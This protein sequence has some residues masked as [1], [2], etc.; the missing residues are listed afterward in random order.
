MKTTSSLPL[1]L[2]TFSIGIVLS[3]SSCEKVKDLAKF[4]I[5]YSNPDIRFTLDSMDYL[6]KSEKL[7]LEQTLTVNIDSII[8]KHELDGIE[9]AKFE[10]VSIE[11]E[12]PAQANFNWLTSARAT[13]S[14]Q[15]INE[16]E[17]AATTS[18]AADGRSVDLTLS[19]TEVISQISTG[20]FTLRL[21][22]N[23]TPPLPAG[24]LMMLI[25]SKIKMTVKPL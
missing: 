20:S 14:A 6:P 9:N 24:T 7:L 18:I 11:I 22:G 23:V 12:S 5:T 2:L 1:I 19:N 13:V 15:G 8:A 10:Q 21:Y 25:K 17:V 3:F 4:D 16:T